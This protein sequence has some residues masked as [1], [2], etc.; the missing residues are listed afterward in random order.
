MPAESGGIP[1]E[2]LELYDRLVA[3]IPG[4]ERKGASM[5]YTA[6]NGNM[7]S[8]LTKEGTLALRLPVAER[9]AFLEEHNTSL[10]EQHGAV[11]KE[12]VA[13]PDGLLEDTDHLKPYFSSSL[14]YTTA[15]KPKASRKKPRAGD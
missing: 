12:Y 10:V 2:K 14:A 7:F 6:V 11:M 15:L 4:V 1:P 13:V 3:T 8:F 9:R 5:P